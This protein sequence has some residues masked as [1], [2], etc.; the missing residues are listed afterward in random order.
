MSKKFPTIPEKGKL[1]IH[2]IL[3]KPLALKIMEMAEENALSFQETIRSAI[4]EKY[5]RWQRQKYGY[6]GAVSSLH[7]RINKKDD[8]DSPS[9]DYNPVVENMRNMT[10]DELEERLRVIGYFQPDHTDI[11]NYPPNTI[12][13]DRIITNEFGRNYYQQQIN[14]DTGEL[15]YNRTVFT[16]DELIKDLKK[17]KKI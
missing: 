10:D 17:E 1:H 5:E 8:N 11:P 12:L 3:G 13:R 2:M 7:R 14:K 15:I 4:I 6:K 9:D 16:F